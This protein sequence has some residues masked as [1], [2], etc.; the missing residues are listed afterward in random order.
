MS[1]LT[2]SSKITFECASRIM[3]EC[4]IQIYMEQVSVMCSVL[5][6]RHY[7]TKLRRVF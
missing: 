7:L 2:D 1:K 5:F 4:L 3:Y 6:S